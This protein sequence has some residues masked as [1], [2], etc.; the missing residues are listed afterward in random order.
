MAGRNSSSGPRRRESE[1]RPFAPARV[2]RSA[3]RKKSFGIRARFS[4][5]VHLIPCED[6]RPSQPGKRLPCSVCGR[7]QG[8]RDDRACS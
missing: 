8:L 2:A 7:L 3:I 1:S 5:F 4:R 6:V